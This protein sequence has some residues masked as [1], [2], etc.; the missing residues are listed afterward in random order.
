MM[1]QEMQKKRQQVTMAVLDT[2]KVDTE[3]YD[4][5]TKSLK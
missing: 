4:K 1:M 3:L 5:S 2:L